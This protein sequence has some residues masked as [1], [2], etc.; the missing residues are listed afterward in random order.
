[1]TGESTD[2]DSFA[3]ALQTAYHE[4]RLHSPQ[5]VPEVEERLREKL[6]SHGITLT[7][8]I[9]RALAFA[10]VSGRDL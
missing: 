2:Y 6:H 10:V 5:A 7:P 3:L 4:V 9:L 8:E 1:M